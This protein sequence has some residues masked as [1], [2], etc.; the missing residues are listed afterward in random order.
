MGNAGD[1]APAGFE[2]DVT[3]D[4]AEAYNVVFDHVSVAGASTK[5]SRCSGPRLEGPRP[6]LTT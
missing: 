3:T 2:P 6:R 1:T 4:G 5:T